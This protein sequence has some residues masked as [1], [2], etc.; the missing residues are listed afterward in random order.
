MKSRRI[1]LPAIIM[2]LCSALCYA[3]KTISEGAIVYDLT[4]RLA[5]TDS[6]AT[7]ATVTAYIKGGLSRTD[8]SS[9]LGTEATIHDA[10]TGNAV[11]LKEYS[12]QKLMITLTKENWEAMNKKVY[13]VVFKYD[14]TAD[15]IIKG[16]ACKKASAQLSD[17]INITVYYTTNI[18]VLNKEYNSM[19]MNLEGTPVQYDV[20]DGNYKYSYILS[21][22]DLSPITSAK[23]DFP[24]SGYREMTYEEREQHKE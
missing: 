21:K 10:K 14:S 15:M 12:G 18:N 5:G 24:K 13:G 3:Q 6:F 23:F 16:Y 11:I 20:T 2:L 17:G 19:F 1:L 9:S 4:I 8:M 22:L 7:K